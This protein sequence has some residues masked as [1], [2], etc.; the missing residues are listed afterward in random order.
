LKDTVLSKGTEIEEQTRKRVVKKKLLVLLAA[1][2][3]LAIPACAWQEKAQAFEEDTTLP[4][5]TPLGKK[6]KRPHE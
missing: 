2:L 4:T 5:E 3:A 6:T 1:T